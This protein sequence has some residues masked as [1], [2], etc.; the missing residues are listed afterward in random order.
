MQKKWKLI[1]NEFAETNNQIT[2]FKNNVKNCKNNPL[3]IYN[4]T[5]F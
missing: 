3:L 4:S 5:N 2:F 1:F